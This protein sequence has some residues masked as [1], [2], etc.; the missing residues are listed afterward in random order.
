MSTPPGSRGRTRSR[1]SWPAPRS[2]STDGGRHG[3]AAGRDVDRPPGVGTG[4][5]RRA[6][7]QRRWPVGPGGRPDG[8]PRAPGARHGAPLP[9]DRRHAGG[10]RPQRADRPR[11]A[12]DAGLRR[13]D[14]PPPGGPRDAARRTSRTRSRGRPSRRPG[15]S[16]RSSSSRSWTGSPPSCRSRSST[17]R[18]WAPSGSARSSTDRSRS[19]PTATCWS[20]PSAVFGYWVAWRDG[21]A[22]AGRRCRTCAERVDDRGRRRRLRDGYLGD[23]RRALRRLRD[24]RVHE[25]EGQ[26]ELPPALPDHVPQRGARP[27]GRCSP[28]RS[29]TG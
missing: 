13:G 25:R 7:R 29:T 2:T 27:P 3:A 17:T 11:D 15:T 20:A 26:R 28:R 21:R 8:R 19:R 6:R 9:A 16:G 12:D 23:G 1:P 4:D 14:L 24:A 5:P 18:R 10:H 22:V